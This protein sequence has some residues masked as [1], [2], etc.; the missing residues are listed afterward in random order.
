MTTRASHRL[1]PFDHL[2]FL[3]AKKAFPLH[4]SIPPLLL[5]DELLDG[6]AAVESSQCQNLSIDSMVGN[7]WV[8]SLCR[9]V[10][11]MM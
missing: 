11:S 1:L 10:A 6:V 7:A 4:A 2:H 8:P 9:P 3:T 5:L